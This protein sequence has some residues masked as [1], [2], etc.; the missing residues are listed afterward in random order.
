MPDQILT[1]RYLADPTSC[2]YC[3]SGHLLPDDW[4]HDLTVTCRVT[5]CECGA[6]WS[7]RYQLTTITLLT[8][9]KE[10]QR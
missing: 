7:E 8:R 3:G 6:S 2:P 1:D 5:C 10:L 4:Q 9:P